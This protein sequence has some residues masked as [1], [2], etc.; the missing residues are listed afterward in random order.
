LLNSGNIVFTSRHEPARAASRIEKGIESRLG[1]T[2]RVTVI[3]AEEL[4]AIVRA[5]PLLKIAHN[6]SLLLVSVLANPADRSLLKP[7]AKQNWSPDALAVGP[8]V[9]YIWCPNGSLESPAADA[10]NRALGASTTSRNWATILKLST[11]ASKAE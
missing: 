5:N 4:A 3:T 8:R 7:L 1:V 6:P 10:V 9:A 2:S 11:L